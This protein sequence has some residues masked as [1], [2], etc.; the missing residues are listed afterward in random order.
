MGWD[1]M[2]R[3]QPGIQN[4]ALSTESKPLALPPRCVTHEP[5]SLGLGFLLCDLA[6]RRTFL[7]LPENGDYV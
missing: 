5:A 6:S 1:C 3:S 2:T 7:G 4:G